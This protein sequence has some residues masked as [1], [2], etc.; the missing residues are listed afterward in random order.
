MGMAR[1]LAK[2]WIV[3][4]LYAG[5]I[6]LERALASGTPPMDALGGI[7]PCVLLFSAMGLLFAYGFGMSGGPIR[8]SRI[9]SYA[10]QPGFNE[11]VFIAFMLA[12]LFV[13]LSYAPHHGPVSVLGALEAAIRFAV[14]GQRELE[15][16]LTQCSLDGGKSFAGAFSWALALV[17]FASSLSRLRLGAAIVR[18]ERKRRPEPFGPYVLAA[19]VAVAAVFAIQFLFVGTLFDLAPCALLT[20]VFGATLIGIVPLMLAYLVMAALTNLMALN[21]EE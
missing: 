3:F 12:S 9:D 19:L 8:L 17:F 16:L 5:A 6:A 21:A 2:G 15:S 4:C 18:L 7:G 11:I 10:L 13:Q 1:L 20:G 14:P